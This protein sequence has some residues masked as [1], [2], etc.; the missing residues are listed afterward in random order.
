MAEGCLFFTG[1]PRKIERLLYGRCG[2]LFAC[3]AEVR[4]HAA[5]SALI[6]GIFDN[7]LG[8]NV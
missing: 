3:V 5:A 1:K 4:V 6:F 2:S 7:Q 8:R